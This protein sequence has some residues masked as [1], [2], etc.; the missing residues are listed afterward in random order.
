[1]VI[2]KSMLPVSS[3]K[4]QPKY[5]KNAKVGEMVHS[6]CIQ[7]TTEAQYKCWYGRLGKE[8]WVSWVHQNI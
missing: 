8:K 4:P 1:M 5:T 2:I 7:V 3:N 6:K